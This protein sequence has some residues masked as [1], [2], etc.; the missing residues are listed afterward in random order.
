MKFKASMQCLC[1]A[2]EMT[3]EPNSCLSTLKNQLVTVTI[4]VHVKKL[5]KQQAGMPQKK[6]E[7]YLVCGGNAPTWSKGNF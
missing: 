1:T 5:I 7:C 2:L 6:K 3:V 4:A